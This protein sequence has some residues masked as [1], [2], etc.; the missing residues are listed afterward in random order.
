MDNQIPTLIL[1]DNGKEVRRM[2]PAPRPGYSK[3]V[4]SK[5]CTS[6]TPQNGVGAPATSC[7]HAVLLHIAH[8]LANSFCGKYVEQPPAAP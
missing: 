3:V 1:F 5:V 4:L 7:Q 2:S 8:S 6:P